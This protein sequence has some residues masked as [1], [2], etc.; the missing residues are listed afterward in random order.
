MI[1]CEWTPD[2]GSLIRIALG[3]IALTYQ[4]YSHI[5][6]MA[7]VKFQ[8]DKDYGGYAKPVFSDITL[9]PDLFAAAWPPVK[10][11]TVKLILTETNEAA[12]VTLFEGTAQRRAYDR[13]GVK[14][15]LK[16]PEFSAV[17][18]ATTAVPVEYT[19]ALDDVVDTLCTALSLTAVHTGERV[20]MP[21]VTY[22]LTNDIPAIDL[23]SEM[24]A[25]FT[26][27]F[28]IEDGNLYLYDLL[29]GATVTSAP[30][31]D[32]AGEYLLDNVTDKLEE[33]STDIIALT[34][35]DVMPCHYKDGNPISLIISGEDSVAGSDLNGDEV[36]IS[37]SYAGEGTDTVAALT[38]ILTVL[39]SQ[40]AVIKAKVDDSQPKILDHLSLIDESTIDTTTTVA[41]AMSVVYNFD[42]L[43]MEIEAWGAVT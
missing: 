29:L 7:S 18:A 12:G 30:M 24:C 27:A 20:T 9:S 35:F 11:A 25:F 19:T 23:L 38:N 10:T 17:I 4:W 34:E 6:S 8:T 22:S 14:Y 3:D 37:T 2:G 21:T 31:I 28:T 5:N 15:I 40:I 13:V 32:G 36:S 41:R 1:L 16:H 39:E 43:D 33:T 26:H 42:T